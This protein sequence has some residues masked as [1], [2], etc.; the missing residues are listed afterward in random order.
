VASY[1]QVLRK[2]VL[3]LFPYSLRITTYGCRLAF[4]NNSPPIL[5]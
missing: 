5:N 1:V 4:R 3:P 2:E